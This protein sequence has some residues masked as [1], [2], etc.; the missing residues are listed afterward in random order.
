MAQDFFHSDEFDQQ[1]EL[2]LFERAFEDEDV[3]RISWPIIFFSTACGVGLGILALYIAYRMIRLPLPW[4][5]G[6]ATLCMIGVLGGMSAGLSI[7][8]RSHTIANVALSCGLIVVTLL[9]FGL[10]SFVGAL[11]ATL[12]LTLQPI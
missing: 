10:C 2:P 6:L 1:E 3:R 4:S 5:A 9:F 12:L 7:L 11:A 8:T